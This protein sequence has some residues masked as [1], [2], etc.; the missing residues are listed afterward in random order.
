M[1]ESEG[2]GMELKTSE[3]STEVSNPDSRHSSS[4]KEAAWEAMARLN[5]RVPLSSVTD[6]HK[7][8]VVMYHSVGQPGLSGNL[9]SAQFRRDVIHLVERY[10]VSDLPAVT[11]ATESGPK[12]VALTFDDGFA[13]F[14]ENV[15]P[16]L[17]EYRVP[18]TLFV[19]TGFLDDR[20]ADLLRSRHRLS[21]TDDRIMLTER[22]LVELADE[23]LVTIGNHTRTH[24][25]LSTAEDERIRDEIIGARR[26]LTD[27]LGI[28]V[29]RFSYPYGDFDSRA[30]RT[31]RETH[32]IAVTMN[33]GLVE[34]NPDPILLP[35]V[36][37]DP[38]LYR[39][40]W[41]LSDLAHQLKAG[42]RTVEGLV[43]SR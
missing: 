19:T 2:W 6:G 35:R 14:Y 29:T 39:L 36:G 38:E 22:E 9:T 4:G 18:A 5:W 41:N 13:N 28:D 30:V 31:V 20:D 25:H 21:R 43:G 27:R 8:A 11:S 12:R 32:E 10:A 34:P 17:R 40:A 16:V 23:P 7:N 26:L 1:N 33:L 37:C 24:P 42:V 15:L 3:R